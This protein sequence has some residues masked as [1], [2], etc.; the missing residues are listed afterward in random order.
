M[1][2]AKELN[3]VPYFALFSYRTES[4]IPRASLRFEKDWYRLLSRIYRET[5]S[6][7]E[8]KLSSNSG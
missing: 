5:Q 1:S 3:Y 7:F 8:P 2:A 6:F 4:T